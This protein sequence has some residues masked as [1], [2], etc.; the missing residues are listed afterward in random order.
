MIR[1]DAILSAEAPNQPSGDNVESQLQDEL[2]V[3]VVDLS[4]V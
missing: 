4:G 1:M 3:G 2:P